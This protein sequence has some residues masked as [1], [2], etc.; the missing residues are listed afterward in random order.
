MTSQSTMSQDTQKHTNGVEKNGTDKQWGWAQNLKIK[1]TVKIHMVFSK[2]EGR[3]TT[4]R[5][6]LSTNHEV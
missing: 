6:T 3:T 1:E 4:V 2:L 5:K